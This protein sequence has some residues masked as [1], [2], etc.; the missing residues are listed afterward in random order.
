MKTRIQEL[1]EEKNLSQT[2]LA[3]KIGTTQATLSKIENGTSTPDAGLV[4]LIADFFM[5]LSITYC[6]FPTSV[7]HWKPSVS[8]Q[9]YPINIK[10]SSHSIRT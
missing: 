8:S 6:A 1:R 4:I 5:F 3:L 10:G 7:S 2:N 9:A